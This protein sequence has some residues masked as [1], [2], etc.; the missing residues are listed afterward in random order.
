MEILADGMMGWILRGSVGL[1]LL[2]ALLTWG[3]RHLERRLMYFPDATRTPPAALGLSGVEE[4]EI[5]T[6]DGETILGWWSEAVGDKPTLLYFHGNAGSLESR[7]ERFRKYTA[8]GFGLLMMSYRGFSGSSGVPSEHANVADAKLAYDVLLAKGVRSDRIVLYGESLGTGVAVQLAAEK[9]VAGLVLDAPYTSM[10]AL[11][12]LHHPALPAR[13]FLSDRYDS[14]RHIGKVTAPILIVHGEADEVIPV[15]MGRR[16]HDVARSPKKLV[17][18]A[19]AGHS[20]HY[21]FGSYDVIFAWLEERVR[22]G[23][24]TAAE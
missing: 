7:S 24:A 18:L 13:V 19:G 11:A 6:P 16:L 1:L 23:S 8:R 20:D 2:L 4:V 5:K 12:E 17:T 10:L 21:L 14:E 22:A 15:D 3:A 9:P